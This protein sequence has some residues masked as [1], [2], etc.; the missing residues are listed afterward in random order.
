M[1]IV[2]LPINGPVYKNID[3]V[4][5][6]KTSEILIDGYVNEAEN[7][8]KRPG[9]LEHADLDTVHGVDGVY[10]W[11]NLGIFIAVSG[12]S[13]F[14]VSQLGAVTD[15]TGDGLT[16][17]TRVSFAT[18]GT[19]LIMAN[20]GRMIHTDGTANTAFI[21]DGDAPTAVTHVAFIDGYILANVSGTGRFQWSN[22]NN[23]LTW[24]A[25]DFA[26]AEGA[27][28]DLVALHVGWREIMLFGSESVETWFNDGVTPFIRY[29]QGYSEGGCAAPHTI[30]LVDNNWLYMDYKRHIVMLQGRTPKILST[31]FDKLI[32][33]M[34]TVSD[35][36][37]DVIRIEG[38]AFYVLHFPTENVTIA[39]NYKDNNW[40]QWGYWNT[41][42]A[43]HDRWL[44]NCHEYVS[45]WNLHLVGSRNSSKIYKMSSS[46]LDDD[47]DDIRMLRRT[48]HIDHDTSQ[49]KRSKEI[50]LRIKRGHGKTDNL[51]PND[52]NS[53]PHFSMR[54]RSDGKSNWSN[55]RIM[56][57]QRVGDTDFIARLLG[58]GIYRTRQYEIIM[59]DKTPFVLVKGEEEIQVLG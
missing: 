58:L 39:Y 14:K 17:G 16:V 55:E 31:P 32:Q 49:R 42:T 33:D 50:T 18:D 40:T 24:D 15:I 23:A 9:L 5:L 43:E 4:S 35:A 54:W 52:V 36:T 3:P 27:P 34:T 56:S 1:S 13:I 38:T 10:W 45:N 37:A 46:Y 2:P 11:E 48:G 29:G 12:G 30:G 28:D 8:V 41:I 7:S 26:T 44:G 57:L 6:S 51:D 47:G 20:G 21:A 53:I 25:L 59:S 19:N 22:L